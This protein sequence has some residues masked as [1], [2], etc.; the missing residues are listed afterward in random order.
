MEIGS[1]LTVYLHE[2]SENSTKLTTKLLGRIKNMYWRAESLLKNEY[3]IPDWKERI[4]KDSFCIEEL[5]GVPK[6]KTIEL[7]FG[8]NPL[9]IGEIDFIGVP[10][11]IPSTWMKVFEASEE[12]VEGILG[13]K[14]ENSGFKIKINPEKMIPIGFKKKQF[15]NNILIVGSYENFLSLTLREIL[16]FSTGPPKIIFT[17]KASTEFSDL[18]RISSHEFQRLVSNG[19]G[20]EYCSDEQILNAA[21]SLNPPQIRLLSNLLVQIREEKKGE[22]KF[23][24]LR[25]VISKNMKTDND[26]Y[27]EDLEKILDFLETRDR[28][29]NSLMG[30]NKITVVDVSGEGESKQII[31]SKFLHAVED[32]MNSRRREKAQFLEFILVIEDIEDYVPLNSQKELDSDKTISKETF[33][34]FVSHPDTNKIGLIVSTRFPSRIDPLVCY[35]CP[36]RIIGEVF[37]RRELMKIEE[38][39]GIDEVE[40]RKLRNI[41]RTENFYGVLLNFPSKFPVDVVDGILTGR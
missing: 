28:N 29:L 19:F 10:K 30:D 11:K 37:E 4:K 1:Y 22:S 14:N 7:E 2:K 40:I 13:E 25:K 21:T 9:A 20:F 33:K 39:F 34:M 15:M 17:K 12:E 41:P 6:P 38:V 8:D 5:K 27:S 35:L 23:E 3:G 31:F 24:T 18:N 36:N 16:K 26:R 32:E